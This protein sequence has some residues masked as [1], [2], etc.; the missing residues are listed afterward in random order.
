MVSEKLEWSKVS[1][2]SLPSDS[3]AK[4]GATR[5]RAKTESK[6]NKTPFAILVNSV[7]GF[8]WLILKSIVALGFYGNLRVKEQR[9]KHGDATSSFEIFWNSASFYTQQPIHSTHMS[10]ESYVAVYYWICLIIVFF[11]HFYGQ[12]KF[13]PFC[14]CFKFKKKKKFLCKENRFPFS[15]LVWKTVSLFVRFG[16]N[17]ALIMVLVLNIFSLLW[18]VYM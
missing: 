16:L 3:S 8:H 6:Q 4:I 9:D 18:V 5:D 15:F 17:S 13:F 1:T 12:Y 2:N 11:P 14:F 7:N 10:F